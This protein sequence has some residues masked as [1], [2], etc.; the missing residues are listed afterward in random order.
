M[1][2]L[3]TT[4]TESPFYTGPLPESFHKSHDSS[5]SYPEVYYPPRTDESYPEAVDD[6]QYIAQHAPVYEA[7]TEASKRQHELAVVPVKEDSRICGLR[8]KTF[9]VVLAVLLLLVAAAI[10]G[11]VGGV[12]GTRN[13]SSSSTANESNVPSP[14]TSSSPAFSSAA[15]SSSSG[16]TGTPSTINATVAAPAPIRAITATQDEVTVFVVWQVPNGDLY[17][18]GYYN[19]PS[20]WAD[21][22]KL[23]M[24]YPAIMETPLAAVTWRYANF[25]EIRIH[26]TPSGGTGGMGSLIFGCYENGTLC[27]E[28]S[29]E[30]NSVVPAVSVGKG[31]AFVTPEP[32]YL[33]EFYIGSDG[34][35]LGA[36]YN[37]TY[38]WSAPKAISSD[39]KAHVASPIGVVMVHDEIWLF[40]FSAQ[41]QLQFATS[42]YTGST[43]SVAQ[44][45]TAPIPKELPRFLRA[46]R[47]D[48][49]DVTQLYYLD[50][51]EMQQ[52]QYSNNRWSIGDFGSSMYNS[53]I[54]N[55]PLGAVGWNATA[56]RLYYVVEGG[57]R[58]VA[59]ESV[60]GQWLIGGMAADDYD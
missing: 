48:T 59:S 18:H 6:G 53:S 51:T 47:S 38:G 15:P 41:K 21:P 12:L 49:P 8:R 44:N 46:V 10:G 24:K 34:S 29:N 14:S 20:V 25:F 56:V 55:G 28:P 27:T 22:F 45:I 23:K 13:K 4:P 39:A 16:T 1:A 37:P 57:I 40:W 26:Y 52:V 19:D 30:L 11:A 36:G 43:W 5:H 32:Y 42:A 7:V 9:F 31:I 58:E 17:M 33:R 3:Q 50:G 2:G 54:S 60:Y 35:V